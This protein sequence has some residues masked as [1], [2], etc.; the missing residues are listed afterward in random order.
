MIHNDVL[1]QFQ[2]LFKTS[3]PPL[4]AVADTPADQ[5]HWVPSQKLPAHVLASLPN[6]R[7][8]VSVDD[9]VIDMNLPKNTQPGDNIELIFVTNQPRLTF[10]LS[11]ETQSSSRTNATSATPAAKYTD[12]PAL[13]SVT[14]GGRAPVTLSD[15]ARFLGTLLQK[16]TEKN[17]DPQTSPLQK[18]EPLVQAPPAD[19]K[20]FAQILRGAL[21][22]SGLFYES[23]QA[24]WISGKRPLIELLHEPQGKLSFIQAD[25][26]PSLVDTLKTAAFPNAP[27]GNHPGENISP[28]ADTPETSANPALLLV[29]PSAEETQKAQ[30]AADKNNTAP[31][32]ADAQPT[33]VPADKNESASSVRDPQKAQ[34]FI[35]PQSDAPTGKPMEMVH[36]DTLPLIQQQLHALDTHQMVWQGQIWPGQTM[37]WIVEERQGRGDGTEDEPVNWQTKLRLQLPCLGNVSAALAYTAQGLR[38]SLAASDPATTQTLKAAQGK[39]Q[40]SLDAAGLPLLGLTVERN[41]NT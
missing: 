29:P 9:Q 23:H 37:E 19:S 28:A 22:Q 36:P 6:G 15:T 33:S 3:A 24:Q 27:D 4:L 14:E 39:L 12:Q 21:S 5:P 11:R 10:I 31:L 41:E 38:I 26:A 18:T 34:V 32:L 7:F 40:S 16:V 2:L 13:P 17:N 30:L 1:N 20:E 8:Q 25:N 35:A